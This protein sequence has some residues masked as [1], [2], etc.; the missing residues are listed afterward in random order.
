[1]FFVHT[2]ECCFGAFSTLYWVH[3]AIMLI[4]MLT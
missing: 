3:A 2:M 1:M 4:F